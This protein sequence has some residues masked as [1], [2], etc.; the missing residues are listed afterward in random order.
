MIL[1][2]S[3]DRAASVNPASPAPPSPYAVRR[4][5]ERI[6][7]SEG[8]R[9]SERLCRFLRFVVERQIE[10]HGE[11]LKESV[12]AVEIFDR[13][14]DYDSRTDSI[15][16]V[17][18]R[19]LR[20]KLDRYYAIE[21]SSSPVVISLPKG[22]YVPVFTSRVPVSDSLVAAPA[23][24][25]AGVSKTF[26]AAIVSAAIICIA[27]TFFVSRWIYSPKHSK[28]SPIRRITAQ[29]GL[30][31]EPALSPDGKLLAYASDLGG[32]GQL[33]IWVQQASGGMPRRLTDHPGNDSNPSFSPDG[34][35]IAYRT[36]GAADGIYIVPSLG[37]M[38]T[39]LARGGYRPRF[40][41]DGETIAYWKGERTF[42]A[43]GIFLVKSSGGA[44]TQLHGEFSYASY[45]VWSPDGK[46]VLF[47]GSKG[48]A[49]SWMAQTDEWDWWVA[50]VSGGA[51]IR[52]GAYRALKAQN[53]VPPHTG[54]GHRLV[55]PYYWTAS[56]AI[57]FSG[58]NGDETNIWKV[59]ISNRS[60]RI[61]GPAEQ[62]TFGVGRQDYPSRDSAGSLVF[63]ALTQKSDIWALPAD[64]NRAVP[65]GSPVQLTDDATSYRDPVVSQD[66]SRVAFLA[67]RAGNFDVWLRDLKSGGERPITASRQSE[68]SI[69]L[70]ADG[71][72]VAFGYYLPPPKE[73]VFVTSL[74][75]TRQRELCADC[76]E[77]RAWLPDL[78][79]LICQHITATESILRLVGMNGQAKTILKSTQTAF[80]SP[81][82]TSDGHWLALVLRKPPTEH[83]IVAVPFRNGVASP[84]S[85]WVTI[86]D[87]G[88]WVDKPRWSP[89]GNVIYYVSDQ[90]GFV[91]IWARH[92]HPLTKKPIGD[93]VPMGHFHRRRNSLGTVYGF[94]LSVAKDK[95]VFNVGENSGEIWSLSA[96]Q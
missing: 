36:E 21:G 40:S 43:A 82:I 46:Y 91:C 68:D 62:I 57:I 33:Q 20:E 70:S 42:L 47:V 11:H 83:K 18:A 53:I 93:A 41:P 79:A 59:P 58:R 55:I 26:L 88:Y 38:S 94:E 17:E 29:S 92:L 72:L 14:T 1:R 67:N 86:S 27:A 48:R 95:L 31:V 2:P 60:W 87:G 50:P 90:D 78:S 66:G 23:I 64:I 56:G 85:E 7:A 37:G 96:P 84:E 76:G 81:S 39:L 54:W 9:Y 4:E 28:I 5:L 80:F 44:P 63:S 51:A 61:T 25:F 32:T 65:Q 8:L 77:P 30:T 89:D 13:E 35:L 6:L 22:S 52:T 74:T 75:E 45:P 15:V 10:G 73:P 19:R 3:S 34:S 49:N 69:A 71:S 16:R 12:L 24:K